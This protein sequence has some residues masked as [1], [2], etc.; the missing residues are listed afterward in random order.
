MTNL[1]QKVWRL[2]DADPS[3]RTDIARG[4]INSRA[5]AKYILE[6]IE[7]PASLN[8]VISAVRRYRPEERAPNTISAAI[9]TLKGT[10]ISSKSGIAGILLEKDPD[11]ERLLPKVFAL[12]KISRSEVLRIVQANKAI[13]IV[14]DEKNLDKVKKIF[15]PSKIKRVERGLAEINLELDEK[16]WETPG[17]VAAIS[18]ELAARGINLEEFMSCMPEILMLFKEQY[19]MKAHEVLY[20]LVRKNGK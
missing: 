2:I 9:K 18:A 12:V 13:L 14:I 5:L 10:T 6:Q 11:T 17:I 8:A 15:P 4:V 1:T 3:L 20:E 19:L 7:E 16:S